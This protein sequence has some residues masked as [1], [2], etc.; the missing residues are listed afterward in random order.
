MR[1]ET[2][3]YINDIYQRVFPKILRAFEESIDLG[4]KLLESYDGALI[5]LPG[6]EWSPRWYKINDVLGDDWPITAIEWVL[7]ELMRKGNLLRAYEIAR[8]L[9]YKEKIKE[10]GWLCLEKDN[11]YLAYKI[12][13]EIGDKDL[14]RFAERKIE[15]QDK[16]LELKLDA[17]MK[18][19]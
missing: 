11:Y 17:Q 1:N 6:E 19:R 16:G 10:I 18:R 5:R 8:D 3:E 7:D 14:M 13:R 15:E 9:E 2:E 12:G 4:C